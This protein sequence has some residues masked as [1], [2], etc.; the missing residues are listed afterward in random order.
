VAR[1]KRLGAVA[2]AGVAIP[3][4]AVGIRALTNGHRPGHPYFAGAP[5]LMAHRG[6][7]DLAPENTMLAFRRAMDWWRADV[8]E[9]DVNPTRD[10]EAVV[11]HDLTLDRTT[12]G[13]GP[14]AERSL[15]ELRELDAGY[16]FTPDGGRS[17]P[18]RGRGIRIPTLHEVLGEFPEMRINVEIKDGRVQRRVWEVVHELNATHRVLIASG[19]LRNRSLFDVYAGARSASAEEMYLFLALH[20]VHAAKLFYPVVDAFQMPERSRGRQVLSPRFVREVQAR[21]LA[22]HVWTVNEE[23]DMRR[24]LEW[25]ADGLITDRPDTLA[26][27]LND[28]TGRPLPPGPSGAEPEAFMERLLRAHPGFSAG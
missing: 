26:R 22:V 18:F 4:L 17:F 9:L 19:K 2:A 3:A 23:A 5:L 27:V 6:G 16:G 13:H 14:V 24:L 15:D 11:I 21:N 25:G 12:D 20:L 10:G 8:L 1:L 28:V 7:A